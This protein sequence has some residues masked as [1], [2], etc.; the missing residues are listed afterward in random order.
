MKSFKRGQ[1]IIE[2]DDDLINDDLLDYM[3][4]GWQNIKN[5]VTAKDE[6]CTRENKIRLPGSVKVEIVEACDQDSIISEV[7]EKAEKN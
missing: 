3:I 4:N 2:V 6:P 1:Q 7:K 5:P